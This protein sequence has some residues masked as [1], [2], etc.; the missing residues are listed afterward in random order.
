MSLKSGRLG[1][2][3]QW[4]GIEVMVAIDFASDCQAIG[5]AMMKRMEG[6]LAEAQRLQRSSLTHEGGISVVLYC[7]GWGR[8]ARSKLGTTGNTQWIF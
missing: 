1:Q 6:L 4:R 2:M 3:L 5:E 7:I 8:K